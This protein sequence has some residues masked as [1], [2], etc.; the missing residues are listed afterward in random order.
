M[1]YLVYRNNTPL[2]SGVGFSSYEQARQM[3]RKYIRQMCA[4]GK[5]DKRFGFGT[6]DGT[7]RNPPCF[8][9][10]GFRIYKES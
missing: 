1:T 6:W 7:S 10:A 8:T 4:R 3:V 2:F 9:R 5:E